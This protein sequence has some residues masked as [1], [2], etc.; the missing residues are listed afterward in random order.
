MTSVDGD[1]QV[2][3][4][5][6]TGA[7]DFDRVR[8]RVELLTRIGA[9]SLIIPGRVT[10]A[11]GDL[12]AVTEQ[13]REHHTL[14]SVLDARGALRAGECVWLGI[15]VADALAV[16]HKEGLAHGAIDAEA[17]VIDH[18]TV[19][20]SRLV[21]GAD[22]ASAEGD[23]EALGRLLASAVRESDAARIGAWAE[24]MTHPDP[25]GRPAAAM[26][27]RALASC[28][29]P[30]EIALTAIGVA[31][32]MR[33]AAASVSEGGSRAM[34]V[35]LAES[36]WWRLRLKA[37]R[38]VRRLGVVIAGLGLTCGLGAGVAFATHSGPWAERG[39]A[40]PAATLTPG[41]DPLHTS[42][43]AGERLTVAR[44]DALSRG[45]GG[46]LVALTAPGS[47]ARAEAEQTASDLED[48]LLSVEGLQGSVEDC[49]TIDGAGTG[50][51]SDGDI[52]VVRVRYRLSPHV[53]TVN[54]ERTSYEGFEQTVDLTIE[55]V[56]GSGWLV[57]DAETVPVTGA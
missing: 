33:R 1:R 30:E 43:S 12:V 27:S 22:D 39:T 36:R 45:D 52:S 8:L 20:L 13:A 16:L 2:E 10:M 3:R 26:V 47:A 38:S 44:F 51:A 57:K 29:P 15:A 19:R 28:A 25:L 5:V 46:A 35:P 21:D 7:A 49:V 37:S 54:G 42:A 14:R 24:P 6:G 32:A 53:V 31:S 55:W 11:R 17:I 34:T 40:S 56:E 23:I 9:A 50:A 4:V 48:G 41:V 18:G